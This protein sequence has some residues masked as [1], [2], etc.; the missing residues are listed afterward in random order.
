[1]AKV[2]DQRHSRESGKSEPLLELKD[3]SKTYRNGNTDFH[4]LKS[5]SLQLYAGEIYGIIGLSGAG[6]STLLRSVNYL[7]RPES[8]S[9]FFEGEC[10]G[11]LSEAE[12]FERRRHIG[13]IF[14]HFNLFAQ[15][16]VAANVAF[17]LRM[18]GYSRAETEARV[19]ELLSLVELEDKSQSYPAQLSGG[20]A[21]R[22]A[23]ARALALKPKL[24][25][26]DE[27]TS[28]L[29][30]ET[31]RQILLLL[32]RIC[33]DQKLALLM[34][35][36]QLEAARLICDRIA[37]MEAGEIVEE[38]TVEA[39]FLEAKHPRTRA[40]VRALGPEAS[41]E[42]EPVVEEEISAAGQTQHS[43]YRFAFDP[44][45]VRRSMISQLIRRFDLEVNFL[46]AKIQNLPEASVGY[47]LVELQGEAAQEAEA[48]A[49]LQAQGVKTEVYHE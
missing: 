29:D 47:M 17:P 2:L 41:L 49:W 34:I 26:S 22:V 5:A 19:Q 12:L 35:T 30:P 7:E 3:I 39:L 24:L 18:A 1:M 21:Q 11:E 27:G 33:H 43:V 9:V 46:E 4:A 20:Q 10:L 23:I 6:K 44:A 37:V 31:A 36:H 40:L 32:R 28:A 25:L 42:L 14:Q 45:T 15:R 48:L 38:N 8:G 16:T 13:M